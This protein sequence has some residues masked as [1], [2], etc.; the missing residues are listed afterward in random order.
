MH[1]RSSAKVGPV[2]SQIEI[3]VVISLQGATLKP[4]TKHSLS[5]ITLMLYRAR[6]RL[7]PPKI[8]IL[9]VSKKAVASQ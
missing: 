2:L 3:G 1:T 7:A 6:T 8:T 9:A 5:S 4:V